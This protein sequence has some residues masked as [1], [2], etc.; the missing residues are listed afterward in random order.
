MMLNPVQWTLAFATA[1][2]THALAV[3]VLPGAL[4][5]RHDDPPPPKPVL[6]SLATTPSALPT[7]A[8]TPPAPARPTPPVARQPAPEV[9]SP[10]PEV[11]SPQPAPVSAINPQTPLTRQSVAAVNPTPAATPQAAPSTSTAAV[12]DDNRTPTQETPA[13]TTTAAAPTSAL[14]TVDLAQLQSQYGKAARH[15]LNK[16]KRYPPR[17][18]RYGYE[19][20]VVV[21]FVV[22]RHGEVL[23]RELE[24]SSGNILLDKEALAAIRRAKLPGFPEGLAEVKETITLRVPIQFQLR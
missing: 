12:S 13:N 10:T 20:T 6:V 15:L 11:V 21:T 8:V 14:D 9:P 23:S 1:L 16:Q 22:N 5:R 18:E 4:S 3:T 7:P 24:R 2:A 19:G 17:A